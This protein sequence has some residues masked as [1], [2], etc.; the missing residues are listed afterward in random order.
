[1]ESR[2]SIP[3]EF[4]ET[5]SAREAVLFA[6][7]PSFLLERLRGDTSAAYVADV[8]RAEEILDLLQERCKRPPANP[9]DLLWIYVFLAALSLK[10]DSPEFKDKLNALN[11]SHVQWGDEIRLAIT[12]EKTSTNFLDVHYEEIGNN[13]ETGTP[14]NVTEGIV[15]VEGSH[16]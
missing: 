1:M 9:L 2:R 16:Q 5:P 8:L 7:T 14:T 11:L 10:D 6:N 4:V 13:S 3:A 15:L 12:R